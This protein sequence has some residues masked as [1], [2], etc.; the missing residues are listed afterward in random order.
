MISSFSIAASSLCRGRGDRDGVVLFQLISALAVLIGVCGEY[1]RG[2]INLKD[3]I[4]VCLF[5]QNVAC[6]VVFPDVGL[7]ENCVILAD[8][9]SLVVIII[10]VKQRIICTVDMS[11]VSNVVVGVAVFRFDFCLGG[12]G[13]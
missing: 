5:A 11:Y 8:K 4:S 12:D 9:L 13:G 6:I 3:G 1:R 2:V 10:P 7:A